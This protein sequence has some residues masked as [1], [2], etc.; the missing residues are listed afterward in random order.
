M[1]ATRG[2][3][4]MLFLLEHFNG[5]N[6]GH[7]FPKPAEGFGIGVARLDRLLHVQRNVCED[8]FQPRPLIE[9]DLVLKDDKN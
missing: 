3:F 8:R 6:P 4:L 7:D 1:N 9:A 5:E 2:Q